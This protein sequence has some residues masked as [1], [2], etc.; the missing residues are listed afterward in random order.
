MNI[1]EKSK[2]NQQIFNKVVAIVGPTSSGKS[3]LAVKLALYLN[4]PKN[5]RRFGING[6]EIISADS[7]QV[8]KGFNL[9]AGKITKKEMRGVPHYMLDVASPKRIFTVF[10]YKKEAEKIIKKIFKKNKLPI[11]C[12]GTGFY[13]D[14]LLYNYNLPQVSPDQKLRKKLE[15]QTT[16]KLFNKLKELDPGRARTI[17][18]QNKRRLIRALEIIIK[19]KKPVPKLQKK[20]IYNLL[21]L[22]I[23]QPKQILRR[24]IKKRLLARIRRGM[25]KE[26]IKIKNQGVSWRKLEN[27]GLEYRWISRYLQQ[28]AKIEKSKK[29]TSLKRKSIIKGLKDKIIKRLNDDIWQYARRQMTWFKKNPEIIWVRNQ[30]EAIGL[31]KSFLL[32]KTTTPKNPN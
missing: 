31:L 4:S 3:D 15:K 29:L 32:S 18:R 25:I 21:I 7:R 13:I 1:Q 2:L 11:V 8:Y 27:F 23:K 12:G 30:K 9:S 26:I 17:D 22:G 10:N 24:K 28:K 19:T 16:E 5:K 6:A 20:S 14:A